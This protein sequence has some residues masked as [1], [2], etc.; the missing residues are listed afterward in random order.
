MQRVSTS[1]PRVLIVDDQPIFRRAARDLLELRGYSVVAE[2]DRSS[3]AFDAVER[4][5]PDVVLLD[6][7]LGTESG[8]DVARA[9][10]RAYPELPVLLV[11]ADEARGHPESVRECGA[12]GFVLKSRLAHTDLTA[13]WR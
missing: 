5:A 13:H 6:V 11:S 12:R 10:T 4:L 3:V 1:R 9:L 8:F 7:C 2:A